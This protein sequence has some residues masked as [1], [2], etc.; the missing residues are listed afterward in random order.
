MMKPG[1]S[2]FVVESV[3]KAIKFYTEKL[4]FDVVGLSI[5]PETKHIFSYAMLRKGK[6]FIIFRVPHVEELAEFS[7]IKRC[8]LRGAGVYISMKKGLDKY[9]SRCQKKKVPIVSEIAIQPWGDRTF[10]VKDPFGIRLMFAE[11]VEGF[12]PP[13]KQ[14]FCGME[15]AS[16]NAQTL[17]DM[18][19]WLKGFGILRRAA[20]KYSKLW[21]KKVF[22]KK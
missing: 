19:K 22:G 5:D 4:A 15:V 10:S 1:I 12:Q 3:E 9:F 6:C 7:L 8:S 11:P 17:E 14:T 16:S 13:A 2:V 21:L 18:I 20:K